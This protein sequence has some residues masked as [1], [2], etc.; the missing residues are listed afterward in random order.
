MEFRYMGFDQK[1]SA[2]IYRFDCLAKGASARHFTV[3]AEMGLFLTHRVAIQE[4]P[5]LSAVKLASD[6]ENNA[7]APHELT[8]HDLS[9]RALAITEAATRKAESRKSTPK[10]SPEMSAVER[11][12]WR[13]SRIS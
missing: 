7:A 8:S 13:G 12:P 9:A 4:G 6:L 2:R 3:S 5:A 11:S 1:G 10:R